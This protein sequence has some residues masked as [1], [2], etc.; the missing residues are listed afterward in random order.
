MLELK[1]VDFKPDG[2]VVLDAVDLQI[3]HGEIFVVMGAS[4]A[5]KSTI[6][7]IIN[8]LQRPDAGNVLV[9]QEDIT[10]FSETKL[11]AIRRK[12][13]MVFQSAALFDSL[14][15]AENVGFGWRK[16]RISKAE[17]NHRVEETLRVVGL[18][19]IG[20]RMPAELSGGMKKRVGLARAI[21]MNPQAILY[22]EPTAG[23]DP[24][25]SKTI[26]ELIKD[27]NFRLQVTSVVVTHDLPGAFAV[28][29]RVALLHKGKI[30]FMGTVAQMKETAIPLVKEFVTGEQMDNSQLG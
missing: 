25:S 8:G 4:G 6:L 11:M 2:T 27:L 29:D 12:V 22:D 16:E 13:G 24:M 14:S 10:L 23:L 17:F 9:D 21:A 5:G 19:G 18:A 26:L 28:A 30:A 7:R 1:G 20:N 15:V 3:R